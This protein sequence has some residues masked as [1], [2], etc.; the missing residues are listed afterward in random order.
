MKKIKAP[1]M[2]PIPDP[3][4]KSSLIQ[5]RV[6]DLFFSQLS[7]LAKR[8]EIPIGVL[9][10]SWVAE[11]MRQELLLER[12]DAATWEA[13]RAQEVEKRLPAMEPGP[14]QILRLIPFE[15][16]IKIEPES[17]RQFQSQLEP[18]QRT[19]EFSGRINRLGY[20]T[21]KI[22]RTAGELQAGYVQIFTTGHIESVRV[23]RTD[24]H[25]RAIY[26]DQLDDD[27]IRS[28]WMY[29]TVLYQLNVAPPVQVSLAFAR[30]KGLTLRTRAYS[31][32][33]TKIEE[34]SFSMPQEIIS[35]WSE[36]ATIEAAAQFLK[37][38]LDNF[39]QAS[40]FPRSYSYSKEGKWEGPFDP[41]RGQ[42]T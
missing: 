28:L 14:I 26:A 9:V 30:V 34:D 31:A 37:S 1:S 13:Y 27:L 41:W 29:C 42:K 19:D 23:L 25:E 11:R 2:L 6:N 5:F 16:T 24:E 18:V 40:G 8:K 15:K 35:D 17:V 32:P 7:N 12:D 20:E 4:S 3:D 10:R 38:T 22:F 39:W 21:K 33:T 36:V